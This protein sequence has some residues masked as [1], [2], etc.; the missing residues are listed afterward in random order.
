MTAFEFVFSLFGLLL[1]LSL[2]EVL[3]GLAKTLKQW[4]TVRLGWLTPLLG[5]LVMLDL[6]SSW[7]LAYSIR[8]E[9]PA[10]YLTL[11]IGLFVTGLYYLAATLVFPDDTAQ[12]R[13]LDDYYFAHKKQ[14]LGGILASRVLARA[15]QFGLGTAGWAYFPA[16]AAFVALALAAMFVRGKAANMAVLVVFILLYP[17]FAVLGLVLQL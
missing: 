1:G 15:A 11:V 9:I 8:D 7:A 14:V 12:W 13:D 5:L 16:F 6:T 10:N 4:R 3:G 2:A 17:V